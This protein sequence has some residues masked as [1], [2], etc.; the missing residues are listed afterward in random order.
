HFVTNPA[1]SAL[2]TAVD[3]RSIGVGS[4]VSGIVLIVVG[5]FIGTLAQISYNTR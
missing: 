4:L 2:S 1:I 5:A 3:G